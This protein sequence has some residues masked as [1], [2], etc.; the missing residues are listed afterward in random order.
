MTVSSGILS[1]T[2]E[3]RQSGSELS[4]PCVVRIANLRYHQLALWRQSRCRLAVVVSLGDYP[5]QELMS[6]L[7]SVPVL[8]WTGHHHG[9]PGHSVYEC[10][11]DCRLGDSI[12][13]VFPTWLGAWSRWIY[14]K[15]GKRMDRECK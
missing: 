2:V 11:D 4:L 10:W 6:Q 9:L 14:D 1:T 8:C 7:H 15:W 13:A 12:T 5:L 3:L